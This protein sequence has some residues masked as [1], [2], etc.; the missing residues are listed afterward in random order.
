MCNGGE[1]KATVPE[2]GGVVDLERDDGDEPDNSGNELEAD[3]FMFMWWMCRAKGTS[4]DGRG[5]CRKPS[6]MT[7]CGS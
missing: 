1:A 3:G 2:T 6:R 4:F 5:V 7:A